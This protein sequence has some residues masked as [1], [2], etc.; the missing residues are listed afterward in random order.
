MF[1]TN[2]TDQYRRAFEI[3]HRERSK[4]FTDAIRWIFHR[5]PH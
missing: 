5:D 4:A 1:E 2:R 3:A